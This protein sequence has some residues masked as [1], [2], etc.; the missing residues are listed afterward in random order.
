[1]TTER[2]VLH[3]PT[4]GRVTGLAPTDDSD[5]AAGASGDD[6]IEEDV[7][8]SSA[9]PVTR[10]RCPKCGRWLNPDLAEPD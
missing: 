4:C 7:F 8:E 9:G 2:F 1:M 6:V 5:D 10:V 3:C